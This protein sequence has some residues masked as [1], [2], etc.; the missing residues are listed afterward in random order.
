MIRNLDMYGIQ[1][2]Y[3]L[4]FETQARSE[5]DV[6]SR[7][8]KLLYLTTWVKPNKVCQE[9]LPI[10]FVH[11]YLLVVCFELGELT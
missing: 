11:K 9:N 2:R 3:P 10:F 8:V 5:V 7:Q 4:I 6:N 1:L